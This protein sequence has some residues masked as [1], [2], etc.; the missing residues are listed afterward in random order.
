MI[1]MHKS[2]DK[3]LLRKVH[4]NDLVSHIEIDDNKNV[5]NKNKVFWM[6]GIIGKIHKDCRVFC[7]KN[8]RKVETL[9]TLVRYNEF[10]ADK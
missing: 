10:I 4:S 8:N 3:N 9:L 2:W 5:D 1:S 7:V 6:L